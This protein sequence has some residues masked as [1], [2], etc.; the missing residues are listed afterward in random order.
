MSESDFRCT[1]VRKSCNNAENPISRIILQKCRPALQSGK[2]GHR[3]VAQCAETILQ[4]C[5]KYGF[6]E[7]A[8]KVQ[9]RRAKKQ[10]PG[11][12]SAC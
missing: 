10:T 1:A 7:K 11:R 5:R 12:Q 8:A 6:M 2:I 9:R 3:Q 4:K